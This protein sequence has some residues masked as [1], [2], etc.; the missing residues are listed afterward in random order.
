MKSIV[1]PRLA[2][3]ETFARIDTSVVE[4]A[5]R[6]AQIVPGLIEYDTL[7][8]VEPFLARSILVDINGLKIGSTAS[9][10]SMAR[11]RHTESTMLIIPLAGH[12]TYQAG[13]QKIKIEAG[14]SAAYLP[15]T[16]VYMAGGTRAVM[17]VE[18][19]A[20]RLESTARA[21]LGV[22]QDTSLKL[23]ID[24]PQQLPLLQGSISFDKIYRSIASAIDVFSNQVDV[25][26]KSQIDDIFYRMTAMLLLPTSFAIPNVIVD[27]QRTERLLDRACQYIQGHKEQT[28]TLSTL[29]HV[30]GMSERS[31]QL[32]FQKYYQCTPMQ[33]VRTQRL[34]TAREQLLNATPGITITT[35]ALL[36]GFNKLSEFTHQYKLRFEELPST[37]LQRSLSRKSR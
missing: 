20:K 3:G 19:D 8:K 13:N 23:S 10:A 37:T 17:L 15:K 36:C 33:W 11:V 7:E 28:I 4:M 18:I 5:E 31:L 9:K 16:E 22:E 26:N 21:M 6:L 14:V 27:K 29:E 2:F 30:S 1:L 25:L 32:A 35:I 12:A 34:T 24:Q